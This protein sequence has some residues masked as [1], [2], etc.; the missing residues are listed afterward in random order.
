[1]K[2]ENVLFNDVLN[3]FYLCLYD[4]GQLGDHCSFHVAARNL[5]Y[6]PLTS[7]TSCGALAGMRISSTGPPSGIAM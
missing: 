4:V 5:L 3:T 6:T 7:L 2:E 1:M